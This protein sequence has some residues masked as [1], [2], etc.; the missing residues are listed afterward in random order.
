MWGVVNTVV[1]ADQLIFTAWKLAETLCTGAPLAQQAIKELVNQSD[2]M[3]IDSAFRL[4]RS[5]TL[6]SYRKMLA[7]DD[8]KDGINAFNEARQ[9][10]WQGS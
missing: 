10:I 4:Q 2:G 3:D 7:S 5:G 6:G 9:P 1:P 8:A